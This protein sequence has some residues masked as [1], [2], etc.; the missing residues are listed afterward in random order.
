[1]TDCDEALVLQAREPYEQL[2]KVLRSISDE[3]AA[4]R[5]L[6]ARHEDLRCYGEAV[7]IYLSRDILF[8]WILTTLWVGGF[9][10]FSPKGKLEGGKR[11][12]T[13]S[14][15]TCFSHSC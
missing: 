15:P 12:M 13:T 11:L 9:S 1:V 2:A 4:K 10:G 3:I 5:V 8:G 14:Q 6:I 7:R